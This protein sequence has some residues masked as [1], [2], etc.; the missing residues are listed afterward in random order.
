MTG[1]I[2]FTWGKY[3]KGDILF[4]GLERDLI[5]YRGPNAE[6]LVDLHY[7]LRFQ[8]GDGTGDGH[9]KVPR[10]GGGWSPVRVRDT[11]PPQPLYLGADLRKLFVPEP[12]A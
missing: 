7:V 2:A 8:P 9:N 11:N 5:P 12:P 6:W 3:K 4:L 10:N 1:A